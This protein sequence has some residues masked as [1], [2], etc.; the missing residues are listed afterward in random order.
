MATLFCAPLV[1]Q[2]PAH[3]IE[4]QSPPGVGGARTTPQP[5]LVEV[6]GYGT[7]YVVPEPPA[8]TRSPRQKCIDDAVEREGGAPTPL[9]MKAIDLK[10]SQR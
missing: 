6:P 1:A 2:R 8:D 7:V 4:P 9:A 10:C 3:S 5:R